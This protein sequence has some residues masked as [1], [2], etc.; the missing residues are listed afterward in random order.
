MSGIGREKG[1]IGTDRALINIIKPVKGESHKGNW[2]NL[3][4]VVER[5]QM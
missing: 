2:L 1:Q 5:K 3:D 4:S